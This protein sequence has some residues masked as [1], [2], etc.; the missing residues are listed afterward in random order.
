[1]VIS[2]AY[3]EEVTCY[4]QRECLGVVTESE[5]TAGRCCLDPPQSLSYQRNGLCYN[6]ERKVLLA[7]EALPVQPIVLFVL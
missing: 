3:G 1:M 2:V 5:S 7:T 6:C 4:A